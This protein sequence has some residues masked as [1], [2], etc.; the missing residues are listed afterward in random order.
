MAHEQRRSQIS[1]HTPLGNE[2]PHD[3]H[4]EI[5][6]DLEQLTEL[7]TRVRLDMGQSQGFLLRVWGNLMSLE[8]L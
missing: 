3:I 6:I 1:K 4:G 7:D 8:I 5:R 2:G